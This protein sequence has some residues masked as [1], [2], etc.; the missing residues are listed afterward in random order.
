MKINLIY[1]EDC[2]HCSEVLE[3]LEKQ[4]GLP[5]DELNLVKLESEEGKR[6]S[7]EVKLE[8]VPIAM[9]PDKLKCEILYVDDT[10]EIFCPGENKQEDA[11]E[12]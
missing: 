7:T 11:S 9:T 6:L 2:P 5:D 1:S 4:G 8:Q 10:V 12:E 3:K